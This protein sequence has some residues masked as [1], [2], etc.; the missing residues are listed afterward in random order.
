MTKKKTQLLSFFSHSAISNEFQYNGHFTITNAFQSKSVRY[1]VIL[2]LALAISN[3]QN[4]SANHYNN[5]SNVAPPYRTVLPQ[6][7]VQ[8]NLIDSRTQLRLPQRDIRTNLL[9]QNK[10]NSLVTK[11]ICTHIHRV[12]CPLVRT[13]NKMGT[14]SSSTLKMSTLTN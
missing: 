13:L 8:H 5:Y 11:I 4:P 7:I 1:A 3:T 12:Q 6:E 10:L 14:V 9:H 2:Y